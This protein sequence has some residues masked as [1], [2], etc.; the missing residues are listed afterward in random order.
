CRALGKVGH[1]ED[2]TILARIMTVD[3][4]ED[5]RIAA[6]EGI[7]SLKAKDPRIYHV[8]L[9]GMDHED[10]A[11]RLACYRAL[12]D[13]TGKDLGNR[14]AAWRKDLE[15]QPAATSAPSGDLTPESQ[16]GPTPKPRDP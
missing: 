11:I 5:C 2:A 16:S 3:N 10:P 7:G 15:P 6:I 13:L 4:L 12:R 8:L 1:I 9:E 14:P